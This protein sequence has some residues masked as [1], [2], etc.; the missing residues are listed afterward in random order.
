MSIECELG[1]LFL[2]GVL[3]RTFNIIGYPDQMDGEGVC[4]LT[5]IPPS[6]I[7]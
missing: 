7:A 1:H 2:C 3:D 4:L 6:R 5:G